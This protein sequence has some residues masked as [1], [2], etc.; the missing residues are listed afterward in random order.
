[1]SNSTDNENQD[2]L[3]DLIQDSF[4]FT[5]RNNPRF[6]LSNSNNNL[7]SSSSSY[8]IYNSSSSNPHEE[9]NEIP[10]EETESN[11]YSFLE[12]FMTRILNNSYNYNE[13]ELENDVEIVRRRDDID[14]Y[15]QYF[16]GALNE[17]VGDYIN[18]HYTSNSNNMDY[19]LSIYN[20][21]TNNTIEN[22]LNQSF[23]EAPT[24]CKKENRDINLQQLIYTKKDEE[25]TIETCTICLCDFEDGATVSNLN[26]NHVFHY[27][28]L[29]EWCQYKSQCPIC[30]NEIQF[31]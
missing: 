21:N 4:V 27:Q 20:R 3:P 13:E 29:D 2:E 19:I 15:T 30:R 1:M 8:S 6:M 9:L 12:D 14:D 18:D 22:I 24:L 26:C 17:I 31:N 11:D 23:E 7:S 10:D 16:S 25:A 28:C 5:I